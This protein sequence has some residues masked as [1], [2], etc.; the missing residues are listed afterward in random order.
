MEIRHI[1]PT[2]P[3]TLRAYPMIESDPFVVA[4]SAEKAELHL[5]QD[6]SEIQDKDFYI[7]PPHVYF[8]GNMQG[9]SEELIKKSDTQWIKLIG[10]P[11]FSQTQ[12]LIL[13]DLE[14]FE[15]YEISFSVN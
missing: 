10:L 2:A 3:D 14:T 1:C 8:V 13:L 4:L 9:Y 12:S 5:E 6:M 15:S 7:Q 11:R